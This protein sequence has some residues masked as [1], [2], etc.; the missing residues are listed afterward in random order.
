MKYGE[1]VFDIAYLLLALFCG[2]L[3]L[4]KARNRTEKQMGLAALILGGGDAFHLVPR[5]VRYFSDGDLTAAL[6]MGKL[7]TSLTMTVFYLLMYDIWLGYYRERENKKLTAAV[8]ALLGLRT[9]LCLFPQNGWLTND[10]PMAW[11]IIRNLPFTALGVLIVVLYFRKRGA[12]RRFRFI[13]LLVTLSFLFYLPVAVGAGALP[14]LGMLMLPK[15]VCYI[16]LLL[17]FTAAVV[18]DGRAET[19]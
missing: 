6:G 10:S 14:M 5:V 1:S 7:V 2:C 4:R 13:W 11:G 19:E 8:W 15:T 12:D 3:M 16:L 17:T 9:A 18:K